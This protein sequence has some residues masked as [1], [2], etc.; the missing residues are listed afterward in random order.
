MA[1]LVTMYFLSPGFD[2]VL[3]IAGGDLEQLAQ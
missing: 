2:E 1:R 3:D